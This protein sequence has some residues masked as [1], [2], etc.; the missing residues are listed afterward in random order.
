MRRQQL[1]QQ[2]ERRPAQ[3]AAEDEE[4]GRRADGS[5]FRAERPRGA[6]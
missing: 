6:D 4:Q 2:V 5:A 1:A 3:A